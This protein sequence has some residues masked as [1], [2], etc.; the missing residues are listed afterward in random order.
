MI[1]AGRE[2]AP[3]DRVI[4]RRNDPRL[5]ID[6][7]TLATVIA[8]D[9][10]TGA[11][12]IQT[13]SGEPR[14]LDAAY[15]AK[16]LAHAYALTAHGAQGATV[17]WAAVIGRASDF[18]REWAYTS[19]SRARH[20]TTIH[21]VAERPEHERERD[22]YAPAGVDPGPEDTLKALRQ[23]MARSESEPLAVDQAQLLR[24]PTAP[25]RS[26]AEPD[27]LQLLRQRRVLTGRRT[28]RL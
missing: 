18:T 3:G 27:G 6:N 1:V 25:P 9:H 23:T 10:D 16:H 11:M 15:V 12:I 5:D 24:Q 2:Y 13:D 26:I 20:H 19:L 4:A 28:L 7:G 14:A 21:V 22:E 8:T 17:H